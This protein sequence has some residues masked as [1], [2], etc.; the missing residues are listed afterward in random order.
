[1]LTLYLLR[2]AKSSWDDP[3]LADHDRPLA[4]RGIRAARAMAQYLHRESVALDTVLCS[5]AVRARQTCELVL[6]HAG[7][8]PV[9]TPELY[10]ATP[11]EM[12]MILRDLGDG[13]SSVAMVGHNPGTE[14]FAQIM[15]GRGE[16]RLLDR[17]A[18]KYPTGALAQ[19][20]FDATSWAEVTPGLGT[21]HRFVRPK[22][23]PESEAERL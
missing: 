11:S 13:A 17:M 7:P 10:L 14:A 19:I 21:L 6:S 9:V 3:R 15:S 5:S 20:D 8:A 16:S 4:P 1:M 23:L 22:D 2:H 18:R 12:L